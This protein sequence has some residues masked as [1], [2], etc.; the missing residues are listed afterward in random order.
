M[1][2]LGKIVHFH[3][4]AV[5]EFPQQ[6]RHIVQVLVTRQVTPVRMAID[7]IIIIDAHHPRRCFESTFFQL[8]EIGP[9]FIEAG[10]GAA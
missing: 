1:L 10:F 9:Y 3:D 4:A 7:H 6:A 8:T 5:F 2:V